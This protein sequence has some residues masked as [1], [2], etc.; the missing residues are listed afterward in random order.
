MFKHKAKGTRAN[1][2]LIPSG[3]LDLGAANKKVVSSKSQSGEA[4]HFLPFLAAAFLA[5][6]LAAFLVVFLAAFFT[7]F[8]LGAAFLA[9]FLGAA[10]SKVSNMFWRE[11][12]TPLLFECNRT[13]FHW[14]INFKKVAPLCKPDCALTV[15]PLLNKL[16]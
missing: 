11:L 4:S 5:G 15:P 13:N 14:S 6:F 7:T 10:I 16:R 1:N 3:G 9:T 12:V 8:F 2:T